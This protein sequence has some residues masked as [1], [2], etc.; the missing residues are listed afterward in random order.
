MFALFKF[1]KNIF[2]HFPFSPSLPYP[3]PV[4]RS[5]KVQSS[6][7]SGQSWQWVREGGGGL[8]VVREGNKKEKIQK[9]CWH[10]FFKWNEKDWTGLVSK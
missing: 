10:V 5:G 3:L 7:C 2:F 1:Y 6:A 8:G 4:V 9:K